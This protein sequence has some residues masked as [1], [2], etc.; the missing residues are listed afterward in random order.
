MKHAE[1]A[2]R[3]LISEDDENDFSSKIEY[4]KFKKTLKY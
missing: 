4:I 2:T 1:N 3:P